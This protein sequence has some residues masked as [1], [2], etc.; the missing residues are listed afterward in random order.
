[1]LFDFLG[2]FCFH[3]QTNAHTFDRV[4][5]L[6]LTGC[7]H[8]NWPNILDESANIKQNIM[9]HPGTWVNT[10]QIRSMHTYSQNVWQAIGE[11]SSKWCHTMLAVVSKTS[12]YWLHFH[13]NKLSFLLSHFDRKQLKCCTHTH[14]H[15]IDESIGFVEFLENV[16]MH[17]SFMKF[18]SDED[19]NGA[20]AALIRLQDTYKLDT[21]SIARGELNGVKYRWV[22]HQSRWPIARAS[23]H[24]MPMKWKRTDFQWFTWNNEWCHKWSLVFF[25]FRVR[26]LARSL[27]HSSFLRNHLHSLSLQ[28]QQMHRVLMRCLTNRVHFMQFSSIRKF[29]LAH[30][31]RHTTASR[32]DANR[33]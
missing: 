14:T 27:S 16:T 15:T 33:I 28:P 20:A 17:R 26:A 23:A 21:A 5:P 25:L 18:P 4:C 13:F 2:Y 1:M 12:D 7:A 32:W 11:S 9:K 10:Y 3:I 8:T 30:K 6:L 19:L 29:I 24:G 31:C 22:E